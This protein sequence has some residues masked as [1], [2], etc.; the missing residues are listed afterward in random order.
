MKKNPNFFI[1]YELDE[2]ES[3]DLDS[4]GKSIIGFNVLLREMFEISN[5]DADIEIRTTQPK[6]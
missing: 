1:H 3:I 5:I 4:F 2:S 6:K